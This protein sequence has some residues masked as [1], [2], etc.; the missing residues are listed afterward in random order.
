MTLEEQ[1]VLEI[2]GVGVA[3]VNYL[4]NNIILLRWLDKVVDCIPQVSTNSLPRV[5]QVVWGI[6]VLSL[7]SNVRMA[8]AETHEEK[9]VLLPSTPDFKNSSFPK[10]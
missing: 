5:G 8:F 3:I 10:Q 6:G 9:G 2:P 7:T 4:V 1:S